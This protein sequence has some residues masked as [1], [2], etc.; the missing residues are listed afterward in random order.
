MLLLGLP[1]AA[2]ML[3]SRVVL[4]HPACMRLLLPPAKD[5]ILL[6]LPQFCWLLRKKL[7]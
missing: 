4:L 1:H 6:D 5:V 2:V 3:L 7:V